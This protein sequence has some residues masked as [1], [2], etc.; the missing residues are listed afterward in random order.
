[1]EIWSWWSIQV[2]FKFYSIQMVPHKQLLKCLCFSEL[3]CLEKSLCEKWECRIIQCC[4]LVLNFCLT[5]LPMYCT[6]LKSNTGIKLSKFKIGAFTWMVRA[7][8]H[9]PTLQAALLWK[10]TSSMGKSSVSCIRWQRDLPSLRHTP[11]LRYFIG[12]FLSFF[13]D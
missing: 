3:C 13:F 12:Y 11:M 10:D 4:L 5:A 8:L 2:I 1:M 7:A 9:L 6:C